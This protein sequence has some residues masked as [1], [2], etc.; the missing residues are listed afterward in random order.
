MAVSGNRSSPSLVAQLAWIGFGSGELRADLPQMSMSPTFLQTE[1][2]N[3]LK[4]NGY[5]I[6]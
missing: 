6:E 5:L 1:M 3:P 2:P 4:K